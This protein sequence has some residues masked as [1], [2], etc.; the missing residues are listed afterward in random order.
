MRFRKYVP[1]HAALRSVL[2][3]VEMYGYIGKDVA[4]CEKPRGHRGS[5]QTLRLL[6]IQP[7]VPPVVAA[8][9]EC[10]HSQW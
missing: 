5:Y 7:L 3:A 10:A 1:H 9:P 8:A 4:R 2:F 6:S